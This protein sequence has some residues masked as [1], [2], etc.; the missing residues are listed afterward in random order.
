[1]ELEL[2]IVDYPFTPSPYS[3]RPINYTLDIKTS[4][5]CYPSCHFPVDLDLP[6]CDVD[7][8]NPEFDPEEFFKP[9]LTKL[10]REIAVPNY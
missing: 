6:Y 10:E 1:M 8:A 5:P 7:E 9:I 3:D 2:A 4:H